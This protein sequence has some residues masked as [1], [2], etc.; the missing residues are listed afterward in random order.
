[1][2][3][4][5]TWSIINLKV[6]DEVIDGITYK[7][8]VCQVFWLKTGRDENGNEGTFNGA[9]PFTVDST[10]ASGPFKPFEELTE[11]DVIEWVKSVVVDE[12]EKHVNSKI[13]EEIDEK[14]APIN[15]VD[16]PWVSTNT[17]I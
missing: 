15:D 14:I 13:Q 16:L 10:D 17:T 11:N 6:R 3:I 5:Y 8:A 12:Y 7:N 9:T 4:T 2:A 1:M